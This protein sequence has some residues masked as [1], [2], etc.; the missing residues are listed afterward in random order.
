MRTDIKEHT[1]A[2]DV[3]SMREM[4]E[5]A[6]SELKNSTGNAAN[7]KAI[8]FSRYG[9]PDVLELRTVEKPTPE[10][11]DVLIPIHA[12]TVTPGDCEIRSFKFPFR[13]WIP[14]RLYMGILN[15]T[16]GLQSPDS[17]KQPPFH[18]IGVIRVAGEM[19]DQEPVL[20]TR[21]HD[22]EGIHKQGAT[23]RQP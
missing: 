2:R 14:S 11:N 23:H 17:G 16:T 21:P 12:A 5:I 1:V 15:P 22:H 9:P 6:C 18:A 13:V 3:V 4:S 19:L 7:M 20:Q 8:C 10:D